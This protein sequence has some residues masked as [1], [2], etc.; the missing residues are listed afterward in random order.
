MHKLLFCFIFFLSLQQAVAQNNQGAVFAGMSNASAA[1]KGVWSLNAN[2]AGISGIKS[3]QI[4]LNHAVHQLSNELSEQ[5]LVFALPIGSRDFAGLSINRFGLS[6]YNDIEVGVGFAKKFGEALSIGLKGNFHQLSIS[7]YGRSASFSLDL[8]ANYQL[9]KE[10]GIGLYLHNPTVQ[11][12]SSKTLK[13]QLPSSLAL[14][15]AYEPSDKIVLSSTLVKDFDE[16]LDLKFGLTYHLLEVLSLRGGISA[17]P[18]QQSCGLG[19]KLKK[20]NVDMALANQYQLGYTPQ[21]GLSY[22]F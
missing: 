1:Q 22:A 11:N 10:I 8:G 15:L 19:L 4:A 2:P 5:N 13:T 20:F 3:P 21:F 9:S 16:K 18:F 14:G 12:Y 17:K 7:N 6:E